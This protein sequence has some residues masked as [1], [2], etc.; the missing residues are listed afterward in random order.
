[1]PRKALGSFSLVSIFDPLPGY[2]RDAAILRPFAKR[3]RFNGPTC[4]YSS[5][6]TDCPITRRRGAPTRPILR[7][8]PPWPADCSRSTKPSLRSWAL[9]TTDSTFG[10]AKT[11]NFLSRS[12]TFLFFFL[13][14]DSSRSS[15]FYL[16]ILVSIQLPFIWINP[17][18]IR[19]LCCSLV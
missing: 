12:G 5:T 2:C 9:T 18:S 1:M 8:A 16:S 6:G 7:T 19:L 14:I 10:E 11:W 3:V 15:R 13:L 4:V 17:V